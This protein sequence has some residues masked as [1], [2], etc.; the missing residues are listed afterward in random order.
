[1]MRTSISVC[2]ELALVWSG[3]ETIV[4][5]MVICKCASLLIEEQAYLLISH[6]SAQETTWLYGQD[7]P[8]IYIFYEKCQVYIVQI[9]WHY[10]L[11]AS[12]VLVS[13]SAS[14]T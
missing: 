7:S 13:T 11:G 8:L 4:D 1:M 2:S 12:A 6:L 14:N 5:G 3:E 10:T 9:I